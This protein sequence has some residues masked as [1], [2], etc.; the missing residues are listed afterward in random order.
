[1]AE[2][3]LGELSKALYSTLLANKQLSIP[4][5]NANVANLNFVFV[6]DEAFSFE[7]SIL[8]PYAQRMLNRERHIFNYRQSRAWHVVEN[9]V[10]IMAGRFHV[11]HTSINAQPHKVDKY[12]LAAYMLQNYLC[13]NS[14]STYTPPRALDTD[15]VDFGSVT[16]GDWRLL[17]LQYFYDIQ[18]N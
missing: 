9:A 11:F 14:H 18:A 12:I 8:K 4:E 6:A 7:K 5:N 2:F 10:G 17:D 1:M 15:D 3:L 16:P 13:R